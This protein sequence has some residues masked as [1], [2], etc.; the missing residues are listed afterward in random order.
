MYYIGVDLGTSAVKLLLMDEKGEIKN[1]VSRKYE[2]HFPQPGWAEQ[3]PKDWYEAVIDGLLE[4]TEEYDKSSIAG[5]GVAGQMHGLVILDSEDV[6]IRKAILWND[7]RTQ[8]QTQELNE[9]IGKEKISSYTG[10]IAFAG[11]TAPKILWLRKHEPESFSKIS[12]IMLPKDYINYRLTGIHC[13][14]Y[15][16]ASGTLLLD[17]KNKT[18]SEEMLEICGVKKECLP[19]LFESYEAVGKLSPKVSKLL[20]FPENVYVAAGAGDNAAAAIGTGTASCGTCNISIGTSGTVFIANDSFKVDAANSLHSFVHANGHYHLMGCMLSAAS[21]NKWWVEDILNS[22]DFQKEQEKIEDENLGKNSVYYLPYLMGERAPHN[23]AY[24]RGAFIG[25]SMDT[26]REDMTLAVLEGVAFGI[27]DSV[28]AARNMG[29]EISRST[30]CGGG[31]KSKLWKKIFANV[32][33]IDIYEPETEQGPG[34]GAAILAAVAA[35]EFENVA[36]AVK[37]LVSLKLTQAPDEDLRI[38]YDKKY[39]IFR[40]LYPSLKNVFKELI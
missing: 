23:D 9:L 38:Q 2:L 39:S 22:N 12:K 32:L 5:I 13:T 20:G 29:V 27:R 8:T 10:N 11:F 4:L 15:S 6:L 33:N 36:G 31:A 35:G 25:M 7:G 34:Y 28:E 40:K 18:W 14:D 17:V 24:A 16:D 3:D 30:I 37:E 21:C 1:I 19:I 26:K